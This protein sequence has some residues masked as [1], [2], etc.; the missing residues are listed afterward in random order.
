MVPVAFGPRSEGSGP[1]APRVNVVAIAVL[2]GSVVLGVV[3]LVATGNPI[4]LVAMVIVGVVLMQ[5]PRIAQQWERAAVLRLGRFVRVARP[6][7]F[8]IGP[9]LAHI[10]AWLH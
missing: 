3:G 6:G 2:L 8:L 7:P 5:A 10:S 1:G 9:L 4:P